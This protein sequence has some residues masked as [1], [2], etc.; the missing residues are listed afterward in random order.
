MQ[1]PLASSDP[2]PEQYL[3][4]PTEAIVNNVKYLA[5]RKQLSCTRKLKLSM[6]MTLGLGWQ[7]LTP[8]LSRIL[9]I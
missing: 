3:Q 8:I 7:L 2:G 6:E 9:W 5:A 1:D 4:A